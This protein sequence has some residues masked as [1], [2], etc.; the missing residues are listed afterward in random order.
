MNFFMKPEF[1]AIKKMFCDLSVN[2]QLNKN[3]N[4]GIC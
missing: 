4:K 3:R 2:L 1:S